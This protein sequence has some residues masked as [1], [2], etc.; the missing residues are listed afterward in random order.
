MQT[1]TKMN[2][3]ST[4]IFVLWVLWVLWVL[5]GKSYENFCGADNSHNM[6]HT[7]ASAN[8]RI[9]TWQL[10][11]CW[12]SAYKG[13]AGQCNGSKNNLANCPC[14]KQA[15]DRCRSSNDPAEACY[16]STYQKCMAGRVAGVP[17]PDRG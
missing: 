1:M 10:N 8:C 5:F 4:L 11:D 9:P 12:L 16:S 2:L 6:C 17:D 3:V 15:S 14:Y 13:C 7:M